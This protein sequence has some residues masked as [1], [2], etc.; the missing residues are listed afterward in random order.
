M[1]LSRGYQICVS[2][3]HES[4]RLHAHHCADC[5]RDV[6]VHCVVRIVDSGELLRPD[7]VLEPAEAGET[8]ARTT[9]PARRKGKRA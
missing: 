4:T 8:S 1:Q 3:F 6:C 2:C 7:C 5:D 9:S